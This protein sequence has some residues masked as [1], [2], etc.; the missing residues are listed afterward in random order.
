MNDIPD[1]T[2][3]VF[4]ETPQ[5]LPDNNLTP[6]YGSDVI[7]DVLASLGFEH[8][9]L[10][11]G[12]SFR[13]LHDSLVNHTRNRK[14]EII[15]CTTETIAVAMAHGYAK[16]TGKPA[17]CIIHDLVGLMLGS[18]AVYN[19]Y[20]DRSPVMILGGCGPLDPAQRRYIDWVHSANTQSDLVK[21]FTKWTSEP[22][23][24]QATV[25]ALLQGHKIVASKPS[26]PIYISID[27]GVQEGGISDDLIIPSVDL[28]HYQPAPVMA[29]NPQSLADTADLLLG[30]KMPLIVAGRFG[31]EAKVT[32]VVQKL[33]EITGAAFVDD[34]SIVC[35]PTDHP[36]NLS[37]DAD[38]RKNADVIL[39]VD[40]IDPTNAAAAYNEAERGRDGQKLI[41]M[42]MENIIPN[43]WSNF[44]A[45]ESA[46]EIEI[47]C[48]PLLGMEQLTA[49]IEQ[50]LNA[51]PNGAIDARKSELAEQHTALRKSQNENW[52]DDQDASPIKI[53]RVIH[54]L[55][56]AVKDKPW[57]LPV[58]NH[59]SFSEG[60]W[61]FDGA[62]HY[63]GSDGG[64]GVG[65][66]PG[67]AVGASLARNKKG[68]INIAIMG[69]GDFVMSAS[70]IWTAA[71][72]QVPLLIVIN[73]NNSWGN[74]EHHQIRVA[75]AR[76]RPPENAWI[77]QRMIDPD[78]DFATVAKG[79]GAWSE[80]PVTDPG[81]LA[82]VFAEAVKQVEQGKV[83]VIDVRTAL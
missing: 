70:A 73:N 62:G 60:I 42:S 17:L 12:S 65:Y 34:R 53:P 51:F 16:S 66:G 22:A 52:L 67:A 20:C 44:G 46:T 23:T 68:Q 25:D 33:V 39:A 3:M 6:A 58:R 69:D 61:Q 82:G 5:N 40:C 13:G 57:F 76:N 26:G 50:R 15:L 9:F 10:V 27:Q 54:E 74:D 80:G 59:R 63:L 77:G 24:L 43:K 38:I 11:P 55:H 64:G 49:V 7:A 14:P 56:E 36:Q 72:Y 35:M 78:I 18:M 47:I 28:P 75:R 45:L 4:P 71:H 83:A 1:Y 37:G 29:P 41:S 30:A 32:P 79:F 81:A 8:V 21:P 19:A 48:D 31:I 2:E